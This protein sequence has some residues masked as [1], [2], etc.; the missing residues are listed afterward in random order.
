MESAIVQ[1]AWRLL[2]GRACEKTLVDEEGDR[3]VEFRAWTNV[4]VLSTFRL[5]PIRI[6]LAIVCLQMWQSIFRDMGRH[7]A[8]LGACFGVVRGEPVFDQHGDV[9]ASAHPWVHQLQRDMQLLWVL[10][11]GEL[12]RD[13]AVSPRCLLV[14]SEVRECFVSLDLRALRAHS[15]Q[16]A[17]P[18]PDG[19]AEQQEAEEEE[20]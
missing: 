6:E 1:L 7:D 3:E 18:S 14:S 2:R 13:E 4:K 17:R 15:M 11:D 12:L 19:G 20:K 9:R 10:D 16:E 8:L 5:A